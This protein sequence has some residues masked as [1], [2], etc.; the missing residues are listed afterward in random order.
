MPIELPPAVRGGFIEADKLRD[1]LVEFLRGHVA[2]FEKGRAQAAS[3]GDGPGRAAME[4]GVREFGLLA[5]AIK[6]CRGG[7]LEDP[8]A[9][10][11]LL[12]AVAGEVGDG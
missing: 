7:D 6:A 2:E 5:D 9:A 11:A 10:A 8:E 1:N 12:E 3:M 4:T